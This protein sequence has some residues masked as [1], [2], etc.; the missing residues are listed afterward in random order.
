MNL[1]V[2]DQTGQQGATPGAGPDDLNLAPFANTRDQQFYF[3]ATSHAQAL[4]R[5]RAML[6]D[7]NQGFATLTGATGMGKTYLR[8]ALHGSLDRLR[9]VRVSIET[10]LLDFDELLLEIISQAGGQRFAV[11]DLPDRYSG[12]SELKRLLAERLVH[13][14]RHLAI[15]LDEAQGLAPRCLENLRNLSNISTERGNIMSV[16]LFG[17]PGLETTIRS[18]PELDGRIGPRVELSPLDQDE[19]R[20]YVLHRMRVAA[21][22]V[23]VRLSGQGWASLHQATGGV[24]RAI[25]R[26]LTEGLELARRNGG[27]LEDTCLAMPRPAVST[28][29]SGMDVFA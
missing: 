29:D 20:S 22:G 9:F 27:N 19:T 1:A 28:S 23:G 3:P 17:S 21:C 16:V 7:G 11:R 18:I 24:P 25:N 5:L 6:E 13:A 26:V 2:I 8:T 4:T 15:L 14:G 10:S 12:L